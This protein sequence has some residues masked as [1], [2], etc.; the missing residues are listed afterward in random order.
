MEKGK[1]R[2]GGE[3]GLCELGER[4]WKMMNREEGMEFEKEVGVDR[5]KD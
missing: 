1:I 4:K 2:V 3:Y 5:G